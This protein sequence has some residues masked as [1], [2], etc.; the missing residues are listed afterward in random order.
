MKVMMLLSR[1][2]YPLDKGDK[3]RAWHQ[4]QGISKRHRLILVCL[5]E[6]KPNSEQQKALDSLDADVHIIKLNQIGIL[7]NLIGAWFD[8]R[9]FQVR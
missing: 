7:M 3:L 9:P 5:S 1:I 4:I 6:R 2:P 8:E